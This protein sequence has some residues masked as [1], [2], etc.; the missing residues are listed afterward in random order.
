M[1]PSSSAT[2]GRPCV[3]G[4]VADRRLRPACRRIGSLEFAA[5]WHPGFSGDP[6]P[7]PGAPNAP[8]APAASLR[9]R[10][11]MG[12][13]EPCDEVRLWGHELQWLAHLRPL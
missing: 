4:R 9:W 2:R 8:A 7:H 10:I 3:P 5:S 12:V 13:C 11:R 6:H 1:A